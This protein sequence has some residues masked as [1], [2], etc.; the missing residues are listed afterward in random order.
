MDKKELQ[1][2]INSPV[3][4]LESKYGY[5][6]PETKKPIKHLPWERKML[7]AI[8]ESD[9]KVRVIGDIKKNLK[10]TKCAEVVFITALKYPNSE[11]YIVAND[12]EQAKSRVFTYLLRSLRLNPYVNVQITK[13]QLTFSNGTIVK[14]L[15]SDYRG[16]AGANPRLSC[17]DEPWGFV[18]ESAVRMVEEFT[19]PPNI[20]DAFQLFTGYAGFESESEMWKRIYDEG[21]KGDLIDD[22]LP[23]YESEEVLMYWSHGPLEG[24]PG[25]PWHT[26][27]YFN[28]QRKIIRPFQFL[29]LHRN[30]W[31][32]GTESFIARED[33]RKCVDDSYSPPLPGHESQ[34]W[35][36][37]DC[38]IKSDNA[39]VMSVLV[40]GENK[41]ALGPYRIWKPS[42]REPLDIENTIGEYLRWL[43]KH[44]RVFGIWC[45]P[46]QLHQ[47]ITNLK[48]D[49]L[50][51]EEFPQTSANLTRATQNFYDLLMQKNLILPDDV[52]LEQQAQNAVAVESSRGLRLAKEKSGRKIDA[53]V[54]LTIACLFATEEMHDCD[55]GA[56]ISHFMKLQEMIPKDNRTPEQF[57]AEHFKWVSEGL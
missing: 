31:V 43:Y 6:V 28:R 35:I 52:E 47:L 44:Y 9:K 26:E 38:G 18:S 56:S 50:P 57:I 34:L 46:W 12:Y 23:L 5:Y 48:N 36:G 15:P 33:W 19:P 32:A 3:D 25:Q 16:E 10:T 49:G 24:H 22:D 45:D 11:I 40:D 42:K 4:F 2:L 17:F 51:I 8:F 54:A 1:K 29:R 7:T 14:A 37:V 55:V 13:N 53:I 30:Q 41:L 20:P 27:E 21:L 39:A